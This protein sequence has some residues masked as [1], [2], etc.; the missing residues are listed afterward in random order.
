[1]KKGTAMKPIGNTMDHYWRV[2]GMANAT[3]TDLVSSMS[4]GQLSARDWADMVEACR[5]CDWVPECDRLLA[6][7]PTLSD[8]P[9]RCANCFRFAALG[10][11][12]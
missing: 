2:I 12:Q 6:S 7:D 5:R 3:A 4:S 1:M 9:A 10:A 11:A 8:A